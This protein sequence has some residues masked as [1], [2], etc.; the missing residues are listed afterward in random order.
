MLSSK[1]K[2]KT[3]PDCGRGKA[4]AIE[5]TSSAYRAL[6]ISFIRKLRGFDKQRQ[7]D[8][9]AMAPGSPHL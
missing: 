7:N 9:L 3:P 1:R 2:K 6:N 8:S 5:L 4:E